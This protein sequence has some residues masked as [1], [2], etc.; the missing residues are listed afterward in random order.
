MEHKVFENKDGRVFYREYN[1]D[2]LIEGIDDLPKEQVKAICNE[3]FKQ[4]C[5]DMIMKNNAFVFPER[6]FGMM[7]V[8]EVLPADHES[9]YTLD[10]Q[11]YYKAVLSANGRKLALH[12]NVYRIRF[13]GELE[14]IF[15]NE[16]NN[17]HRY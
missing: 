1:M 15:Q 9:V 2:D 17:N 5:L 13:Q 11:H 4:V 10:R 8:T 7:Y 6:G 3:F 14:D 12:R 16:I